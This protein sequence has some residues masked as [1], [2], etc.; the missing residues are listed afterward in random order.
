MKALVSDGLASWSL[1]DGD[2]VKSS[3][4]GSYSVDEGL[5]NNILACHCLVGGPMVDSDLASIRLSSFGMSSTHLVSEAP[6]K[7]V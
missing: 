3:L 1:V 5:A 4:S 2:L 6:I 7:K